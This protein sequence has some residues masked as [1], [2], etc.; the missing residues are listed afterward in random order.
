MG[1]VNSGT[2]CPEKWWMLYTRNMKSQVE[3]DLILLIVIFLAC[4]NIQVLSKIVWRS[5]AQI[6]Y[7]FLANMSPS[8]QTLTINF[9]T[10]SFIK[11]VK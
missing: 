4:I 2:N 9:K 5:G 8:H 6:W 1:V 7:N 10:G 3:H 11:K